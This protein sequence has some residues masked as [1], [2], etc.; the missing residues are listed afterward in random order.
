MTSP[1]KISIFQARGALPH[2]EVH[3][4]INSAKGRPDNRY[5]TGQFPRRCREHLKLDIPFFSLL[6]D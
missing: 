6:T 1:L 4:A 5:S 3:I 2:D